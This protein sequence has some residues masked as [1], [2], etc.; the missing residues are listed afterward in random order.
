MPNAQQVAGDIAVRVIFVHLKIW[1]KA[2]IEMLLNP[3]CLTGILPL[4]CVGVDTADIIKNALRMVCLIQPDISADNGLKSGV[5]GIAH[6]VG[7]S[8]I[9]TS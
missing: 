4:A 7:G 8:A 6:H 2:V 9:W 3:L 5:P 1:Y